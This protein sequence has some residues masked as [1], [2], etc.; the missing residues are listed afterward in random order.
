[1]IQ[2][3]KIAISSILAET[4][5]FLE[6]YYPDEQ[7]ELRK[8]AKEKNILIMNRLSISQE[9]ELFLKVIDNIER[10]KR[11]LLLRQTQLGMILFIE[12]NIKK[13]TK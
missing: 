4:K 7:S 10:F 11:S 13:L 8:A 6:E 5:S 2:P 12:D 9:K 3:S 1:M